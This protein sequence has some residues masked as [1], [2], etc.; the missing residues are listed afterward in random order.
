MYNYKSFWRKCCQSIISIILVFKN[1]I[2][3]CAKTKTELQSC[4]TISISWAWNW[5]CSICTLCGP[6]RPLTACKCSHGDLRPP[7]EIEQHY[8]LQQEAVHSK[9]Y[10]S[11]LNTILWRDCGR[12]GGGNSQWMEEVDTV[13]SKA[14]R[15]S[16]SLILPLLNPSPL[17]KQLHKQRNEGSVSERITLYSIWTGYRV[18][19]FEKLLLLYYKQLYS[20]PNSNC[21]EDG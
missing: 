15:G 4:K 17:F 20:V 3:R 21:S 8:C 10:S 11:L 9:G 5:L 16:C 6:W 12:W 19:L 1:Y 14:E 7:I 18:L 2:N 13:I